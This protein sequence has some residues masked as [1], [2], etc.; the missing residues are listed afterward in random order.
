VL[1][2]IVLLIERQREGLL[3]SILLLDSDARRVRHGA[4]PHLPPALVHGIDGAEIGP[5]EGSCGAAA[6]LR[7]P[8]IVDDIGTHPNWT[9]YRHL[10]LPF[11]LRACWS[12]PIFA[13]SG[14]DVLGTFA[15]YTR[16]ARKP[17]GR[18]Q[19]WVTRATDL[20]AIAIC[21]DRA[22]RAARQADA[23]Y[24]QIV[25]TAYEGVWLLDVDA[26]TIFVNQRTARM[27]G[28]QPDEML[29]HRILDFMEENSR[30]A[31]EGTFIQRLRTISEQYEF[32]FRRKDGT[33]FW[34]LIGGSPI[35]DEKQQVVGALGMIT[36]ISA[37]KRTEQALR[38]SEA[39]FR[40]V[41][42]HAAIGM[43]LVNN[44]GRLVRSNLALQQFLG[45]DDAE[46]S[47]STFIDFS[48]PDDMESDRDLFRSF[49]IGERHS[50]QG[51]RRFVRKDGAVA[52]GRLTA[53]LVEPAQGVPRCAIAMI[54]N[55]TER[56]EMEEA[57]RASER[58]RGLMYSAVSDVLFYVGVERGDH[59][60][61]LS[62]NPAFSRTTGLTEADVV[63][64]AVDEVIPE[65]SRA[66]VLANYRRAIEERRTITWDE[67]SPYPAGTRYGE[68]SITPLFD[69]DGRCTNLVGTVHDVTERRLADQRLF[70]QAALL[71]K[72]RDAILVRGFDGIIQYWNQGAERLYGWSAAEAVG[73]D[74]RSML[75]RDLATFEEGQQQLRETGQW[76]G[77]LIQY[78][79]A[80]RRIVL[81]SSWTLIRD[82]EG[83]PESVLVINTDVTDRKSLEAQVF[84]S[85]RL[86]SLG[87][88]AG[89]I[90]HDF[91]NLLVVIDAN[92]QLALS[93]LP[94]DHPT[95]EELTEVVRAGERGAELV[96]QLL[97]FSRREESK[98]RVVRLQ[99]LV[100]EA[101]GLLRVT[102]PRSVR[103]DTRFDADVPEVLAD[104]TQIH[105]IVM[106]LGTNAVHALADGGGAL[107]VRLERAA[108]GEPL[109]AHATVLPPGVYARLIVADTGSGMDATTFDRM[110]DPFFTTKAPGEGTG[111]G[112]SVVHG[113]VRNHDGGVVVHSKLGEGTRFDLYFPAASRAGAA[114]SASL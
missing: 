27:L 42:E 74:L 58:L 23:R 80:G 51:E 59:F 28:Y 39:E 86:E 107:E 70:A 91:N 14:G 12:T 108:V 34:A 26:R 48:H 102:F 11:G 20:A 90:A 13:A 77:E 66:Q 55:V 45:R 105:Q 109:S 38:Q 65:R 67:A 40:V 81:E 73:R 3:C 17:D 41:F 9:D 94:A 60:R 18:E 22:E 89:G 72:A 2:E 63:G 16:E 19:L 114:R 64:R 50:Y 54:E 53:T 68:V 6:Y 8:V 101:L 79:R 31:A 76:S 111:L 35:H 24:R 61:F 56:R 62:V 47:A 43:A 85:Q 46:L 78:S 69:P 1:E 104:P 36:D 10:A 37:L 113:I 71:D 52:W 88:L 92:L 4:A 44:E 110:F 82:E 5:R 32:R 75:Y 33:T 57:V 100:S 15:I 21:R 103:L 25:D 7:Q 30:K 29:G 96:R 98:R 49:R 87:T 84:H 83:R 106:N 112:L 93:G 97:T 95:R 99:P